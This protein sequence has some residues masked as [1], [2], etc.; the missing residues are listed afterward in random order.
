MR[1]PYVVPTERFSRCISASKQVRWDIESDVIRGRSFD[2]A[3]KLLHDGLTLASRLDFLSFKEKVYFSQVQ[4]RTYANMFGLVERFIGAKVLETSR[5]HWLGDQIA[6]EAL[7]R[8]CDEELE[9]QALFRRVEALTSEVMPAGYSFTWDPNEVAA[10]VLDKSSW[11][12]LAL[13][14]LI[15]LFTQSHYRESI[16]ENADLSGLFMDVLLFHWKEESQHAILDEL[17][18]RRLDSGTSAEARDAA[19]DELI[20]LIGAVDAIVRVKPC[21]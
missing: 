20:A 4:G 6:L 10:A 18:W 16:R 14:F 11:A 13:T 17:E 12:V 2:R 7:V 15:E 3:S 19:V 5:D 1:V 8:F 9:H 21:R